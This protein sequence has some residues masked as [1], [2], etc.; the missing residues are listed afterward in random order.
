MF[1]KREIEEFSVLINE[2]NYLI[3]NSST[4]NFSSNLPTDVAAGLISGVAGGS[5][6]VGG[7]AVALSGLSGASIMGALGGFGVGGAALGVAS[8]AA[9][10]VLSAGVLGGGAYIV[11]NQSKLKAAIVELVQDSYKKQQILE[12]DS[13]QVS[14]TLAKG[15]VD[16]RNVL[17]SRHSS[18]KSYSRE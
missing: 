1:K 3:S 14:L 9:L 15:I 4:Q 11:A 10:P 12:Q 6:A 8:L 13:R 18:I 17:F 7:I 2:A 16:Y 5:L